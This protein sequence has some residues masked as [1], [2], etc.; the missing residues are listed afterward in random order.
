[1]N[2]AR[3]TKFL[4]CGDGRSCERVVSSTLLQ[5]SG[6]CFWG[7][8]L[9][10]PDRRR[11]P[12][13]IPGST[14]AAAHAIRGQYCPPRVCENTRAT[15]RLK[16]SFLLYCRIRVFFVRAPVTLGRPCTCVRLVPAGCCLES[17]RYEGKG[18]T[19]SSIFSV[20]QRLFECNQNFF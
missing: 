6:R 9:P 7:S 18:P 3:L 13:P 2:H 11:S 20:S 10:L 8:F 4:P 12:R 17:G 19:V 5:K 1:R 15:V 14:A 16:Q